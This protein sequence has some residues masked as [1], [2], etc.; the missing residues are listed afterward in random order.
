MTEISSPGCACALLYVEQACTVEY[1]STCI[2]RNLQLQFLLALLQYTTYAVR[3]LLSPTHLC[4]ELHFNS[5]LA[6]HGQAL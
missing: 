6:P 4:S 1:E 5:E 2:A 3:H